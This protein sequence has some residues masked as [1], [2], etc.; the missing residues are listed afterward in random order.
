M[1]DDKPTPNIDERLQAIAMN[2]ELFE[3]DMQELKAAQQRDSENIRA[4]GEDIRALNVV[5]QQ[6]AENIRGLARIAAIHEHRLTD[7]E[8]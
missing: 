7:L 5:V 2:H 1:P 4:L 6:D 8:Q 3:H